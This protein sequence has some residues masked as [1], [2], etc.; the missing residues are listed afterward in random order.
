MAEPWKYCCPIC[1]EDLRFADRLQ[2]HLKEEHGNKQQGYALLEA[3]PVNFLV[4][5]KTGAVFQK[6]NQDE[7]CWMSIISNVRYSTWQLMH[8]KAPIFRVVGETIG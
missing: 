6:T 2:Q 5:D 3:A 4:V 1:T 7:L 8:H